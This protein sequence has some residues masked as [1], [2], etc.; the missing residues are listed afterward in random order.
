MQ[1]VIFKFTMYKLFLRPLQAG[2]SVQP[3]RL[4]AGPEIALS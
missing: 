1:V 3:K 2:T 4:Q